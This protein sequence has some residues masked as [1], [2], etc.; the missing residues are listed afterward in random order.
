M[1]VYPLGQINLPV[2]FKDHANFC[3][4]IMT[5][6]VVDFEGYYHAILG[7][8][9][10]AW[11]MAVPN[12]TY[13]KL[14]MLGLSDTI[15]MGTTFP[16]AYTCDWENLEHATGLVNSVELKRLQEEVV[17]AMPDYHEPT[18]VSAFSLTEETKAMEIDP[19]D[20]TKMVRIGTKL[21]TK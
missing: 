18:T 11:F 2:M 5:F 12:Y 15:T 8:P 20:P 9:C 4:E 16:H 13:L 7:R 6:D 3:T 1:R 14:K 10:Y 19:I 17:S 21:P